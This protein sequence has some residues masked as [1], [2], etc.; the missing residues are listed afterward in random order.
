MA[1]NLTKV[2]PERCENRWANR[3]E[4]VPAVIRDRR[5]DVVGLQEAL[6]FQIRELLA[7]LPRFASIGVGRVDGATRGEYSAILYRTD[8]F[9]PDESGTFW[10]SDTPDV[11]GSTSWGNDI[12]R[13]CTWVR[14]ADRRS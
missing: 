4:L 14:L 10:F 3:R 6:D 7:A 11:P 13:I 1:W 12:V 2:C 5:P 8:R 9:E